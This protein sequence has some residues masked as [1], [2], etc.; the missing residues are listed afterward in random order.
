MPVRDCVVGMNSICIYSS[1]R[2]CLGG[3]IEPWAFSP[4]NTALLV[5][6]LR[7]LRGAG[8]GAA[9]VF[10]KPDGGW[11]DMTESAGHRTSPQNKSR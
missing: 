3:S 10:V 4:S 5:V 8:L 2:F 1:V 11:I 6:P 9:Y 7:A